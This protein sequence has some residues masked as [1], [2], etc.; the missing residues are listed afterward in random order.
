MNPSQRDQ[1]VGLLSEQ[2]HRCWQVPIAAQTA[3]KPPVPSVRVKLNQ[4]GS[5]AAEPVVMKF[6]ATGL[7]RT[8]AGQA[9]PRATHRCAPLKIPPQFAPFYQDWRDL[10]VN[11]DP[12]EMG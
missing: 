8:V 12:R 9:P 5:L 10:V 6:G 3:D 1:L 4:D 2:L 11:F 7:F